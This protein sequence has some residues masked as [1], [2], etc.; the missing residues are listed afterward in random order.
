MRLQRGGRNTA[1]RSSTLRPQTT[2]LP[3]FHFHGAAG[4]NKKDLSAGP[5]ILRRVAGRMRG[6]MYHFMELFDT[7]TFWFDIVTP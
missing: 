1:E 4:E 2:S 6:T 7:F 5:V 3:Y